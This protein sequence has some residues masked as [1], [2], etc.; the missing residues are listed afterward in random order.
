MV[1][2][3]GAVSVTHRIAILFYVKIFSYFYNKNLQKFGGAV[4]EEMRVPSLACL[5]LSQHLTV[6]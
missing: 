4:V 3:H 5:T 6:L 1:D 2:W